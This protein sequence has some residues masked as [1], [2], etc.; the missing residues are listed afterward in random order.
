MLIDHFWYRLNP[1][2]LE[3]GSI[4]RLLLLLLSLSSSLSSLSISIR[5]YVISHMDMYVGMYSKE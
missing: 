4:K 5:Y 1:V 2:I 3:R